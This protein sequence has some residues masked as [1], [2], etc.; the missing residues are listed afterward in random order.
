MTLELTYHLV[1]V[2]RVIRPK[3]YSNIASEFFVKC[4][5]ANTNMPLL[6]CLTLSTGAHRECRISTHNE[7]HFMLLLPPA[8][9]SR[10]RRVGRRV[11]TALSIMKLYWEGDSVSD[12]NRV[13]ISDVSA[14]RGCWGVWSV[15]VGVAELSGAV[16][17]TRV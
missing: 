13:S 2:I 14:S 6:T 5:I 4:H 12:C 7:I 1:P 8:V 17:R 15:E 9:L 11:D 3:F 10:V 16:C